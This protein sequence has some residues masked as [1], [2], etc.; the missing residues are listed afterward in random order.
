MLNYKPRGDSRHEKWLENKAAADPLEMPTLGIP[1]GV[2]RAVVTPRKAGQ[3]VM[4]ITAMVGVDAAS[5]GWSAQ[6]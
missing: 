4:I 6:L 1:V 2:C 5:H 3:A